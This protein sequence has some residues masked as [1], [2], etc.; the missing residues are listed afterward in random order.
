VTA[1]TAPL[2]AGSRDVALVDLL[3]RLLAGGV[4]LQGDIVLSAAGIDLVALDLRLLISAID[5]LLDG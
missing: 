1:P 5:T 2:S 4:V 3:D